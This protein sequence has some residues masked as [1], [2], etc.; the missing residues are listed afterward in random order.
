MSIAKSR[1]PEIGEWKSAFKLIFH[2][3]LAQSDHKHVRRTHSKS[4]R[5][6]HFASTVRRT[7]LQ[8]AK[9]HITCKAVK[10]GALPHVSTD[11]YVHNSRSSFI[12]MHT[13]QDI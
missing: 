9:W 4:E 13:E 5:H 8:A 12:K 10:W 6:M 3:L 1:A 7:T 2:R 11:S